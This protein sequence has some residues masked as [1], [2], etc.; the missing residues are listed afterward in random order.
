MPLKPSERSERVFKGMQITSV[1][2]CV[3]EEGG[4]ALSGQYNFNFGH[5]QQSEYVGYFTSWIHLYFT[6]N[7]EEHVCMHDY[8]PPPICPSQTQFSLSGKY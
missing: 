2:V 3:G 8:N 7:Y 6:P 1:H 4:K 5:E